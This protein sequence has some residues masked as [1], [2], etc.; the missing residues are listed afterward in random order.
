M[1]RGLLEWRQVGRWRSRARLTVF[2]AREVHVHLNCEQPL[3][4]VLHVPPSIA[5]QQLIWPSN[6]PRSD[7]QGMG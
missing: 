4:A 2:W 3:W 1:I 5:D 6:R 7:P